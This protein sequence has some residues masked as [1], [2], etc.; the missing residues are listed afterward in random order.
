M[1]KV[2]KA[3]FVICILV[4]VLIGVLFVFRNQV[5]KFVVS[6]GV[7]KVTGLK[8]DITDLN[9][10]IPETVIGINGMQIYNPKGYED[11]LMVDMPEIY[12]DYD[13]SAILKNDIHLKEVR[14][15]LREMIIVKNRDGELNIDSLKI[16]KSAEQDQ[17]AVEKEKPKE[18]K[19]KTNFRV[20]HLKLKIGRV[21]YKDYSSGPKPSIKEYDLNI[22]DSYDNITDPQALARL[23]LV[24]AL[25]NTNI[26]NFKIKNLQGLT[27]DTLNMTIGELGGG[28][29]QGVGVGE[30]LGESAKEITEK[31][32]QAIKNIF[33]LGE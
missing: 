18:E 32:G 25:I 12:V 15:D 33:N 8:L 9:L 10:G 24:R 11:R 29:K 7:K 4:V 3:L 22:D 1:A 5:V 13:L 6:T 27:A 26:A 30:S 28:V 14:I 19:K 31:A 2:F 16:V 20:D 21:V 17:V 23:I